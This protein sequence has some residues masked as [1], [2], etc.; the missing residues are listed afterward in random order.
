M[1]WPLTPQLQQSVCRVD[2]TCPYVRFP[3]VIDNGF[4]FYAL[5]RIKHGFGVREC[6]RC[7]QVLPSSL[8]NLKSAQSRFRNQ[9]PHAVGKR[10]VPVFDCEFEPVEQGRA[11]KKHSRI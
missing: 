6:L 10:T 5:L 7:V 11:T 9:L 1:G 8:A 4:G 3:V 2:Q